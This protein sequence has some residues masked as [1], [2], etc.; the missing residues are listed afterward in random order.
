[1]NYFLYTMDKKEYLELAE[2]KTRANLDEGKCTELPSFNITC[3]SGKEKPEPGDRIKFNNFPLTF[4]V[5]DS[6]YGYPST[7]N[8]GIPYYRGYVHL[9]CE[10]TPEVIFRE[11]VLGDACPDTIECSINTGNESVMVAMIRFF[12]FNNKPGYGGIHDTAEIFVFRVECLQSFYSYQ[13]I[14]ECVYQKVLSL[15]R[16]DFGIPLRIYSVANYTG[17]S[18]LWLF[19]GCK[20]LYTKKRHRNLVTFHFSG[21]VDD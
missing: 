1:M 7:N 10:G 17:F 6:Y 9:A 3:F 19:E 12:H 13:K 11:S 14:V 2:E 18:A 20:K 16:L 15:S 8:A 21:P 4:R 5:K